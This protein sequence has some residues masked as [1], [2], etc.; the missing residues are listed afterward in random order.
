MTMS[1][2]VQILEGLAELGMPLAPVPSRGHR[3]SLEHAPGCAPSLDRRLTGSR[4]CPPAAMPSGERPDSA[5]ARG[6]RGSRDRRLG[7]AAPRA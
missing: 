1:K 2:V 6:R 5:P 4:T 7:L 3:V